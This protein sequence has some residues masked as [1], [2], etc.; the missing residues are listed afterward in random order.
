MAMAL[1]SLNPDVLSQIEAVE[2]RTL[3]AKLTAM[4][5]AYLAAQLRACE[6]E[7]TTFEIKYRSAFADF[8]AAWEENALPNKYDHKLERDYMEWEG[9]EAE[10][11]SWL[12][13]LKQ[14]PQRDQVEA[15]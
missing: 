15:S 13:R 14:L 11:Q 8:A 9:L 1:L 12:E 4:L 5:E 7:I 10:R 2:G 6:Q 3:D